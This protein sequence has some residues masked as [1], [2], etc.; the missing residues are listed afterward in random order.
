MFVL[1]IYIY[2]YIRFYGLFFTHNQGGCAD[3][4]FWTGLSDTAD[5]SFYRV[6]KYC[7]KGEVKEEF[8]EHFFGEKNNYPVRNCCGCG[9]RAGNK[10][11][12]QSLTLFG[13]YRILL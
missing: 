11:V 8:R 4:P 5:C 6:S 12:R 3:T 2:I 13:Y 10:I 9:N 7:Y 1:Y